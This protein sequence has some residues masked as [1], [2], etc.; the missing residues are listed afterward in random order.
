MGSILPIA[1]EEYRVR[2]RERVTTCEKL[3]CFGEE[4]CSTSIK[5]GRS[6]L[7]AY[8]CSY[9]RKA[10]ATRRRT[11]ENKTLSWRPPHEL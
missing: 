2:A 11:V 3:Q 9:T 8:K 5:G 10:R 1:L 4:T 6:L 7:E